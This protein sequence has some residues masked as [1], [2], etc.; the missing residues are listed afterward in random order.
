MNTFMVYFTVIKT[1][2]TDF[3]TDYPTMEQAIEKI[4]NC[5]Q[6]DKRLC[7]LGDYYY[8]IKKR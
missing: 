1:G 7:Q 3:I 8:F 5:Y 6:I 4:A 2:R